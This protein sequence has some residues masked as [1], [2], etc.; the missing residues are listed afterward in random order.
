MKLFAIT[1][2]VAAY[3]VALPILFRI[4][5]VFAERRRPWFAALEGAMALLVVG[6]LLGDRPVPAAI[7]AV[8]AT[9]LAGTWWER[10]RRARAR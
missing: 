4:R 9:I 5:V 1:L 6:Y 10:G 7:N 3:V 8:G 2:V